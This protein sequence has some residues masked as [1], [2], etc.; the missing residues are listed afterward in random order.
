MVFGGCDF[1][2]GDYARIGI[3]LVIL[4]IVYVIVS[5]FVTGISITLIGAPTLS[6][7][8]GFLLGIG[9]CAWLITGPMQPLVCK[10]SV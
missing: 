6:V 9:A 10:S 1:S 2:A 5:V 4:F 3:A 8:I 7:L